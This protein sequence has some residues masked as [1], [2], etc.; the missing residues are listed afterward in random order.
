MEVVLPPLIEFFRQDIFNLKFAADTGLAKSPFL[1]SVGSKLVQYNY[2]RVLKPAEKILKDFKFYEK[3]EDIMAIAANA[4][5]IINQSFSSG[6]GWLMPG[7]IISMIKKGVGAFIIV[8]PFGCLPNHISGRGSI[9]PIKERYPDVQVIS[10]D[11][12]PD[13]S[14]GNIENRLQML[15]LS[16]KEKARKEK[17]QA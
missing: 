5:G 2:N 1:T 6:E 9:K 8:Q 14:M 12:D 16:A 13:T 4:E 3:R 15:I 10:L 11:Y 7:E 17:A